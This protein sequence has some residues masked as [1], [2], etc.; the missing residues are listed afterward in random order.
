DV[1]K[2]SRFADRLQVRREPDGDRAAERGRRIRAQKTRR[3][4]R[5]AAESLD[6]RVGRLRVGARGPHDRQGQQQRRH[7][8]SSHDE[9]TSTLA[10]SDRATVMP[11]RPPRFSPQK[12]RSSTFTNTVV[13]GGAQD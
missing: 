6:L 3:A 12:I 9:D 13:L 11:M 7:D 2:A 5:E 4:E 8:Y 1:A 10:A